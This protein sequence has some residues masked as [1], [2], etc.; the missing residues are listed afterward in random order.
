MGLCQSSGLT[1]RDLR[2]LLTSLTSPEGKG[3]E[4]RMCSQN[5]NEPQGGQ[6]HQTRKTNQPEMPG[7][8]VRVSGTFRTRTR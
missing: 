4:E 6:G 3:Q 5:S 1:P 7:T 8:P 2:T